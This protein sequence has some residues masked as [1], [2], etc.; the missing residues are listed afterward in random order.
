[1]K[2]TMSK[3]LGS[4]VFILTMFITQLSFAGQQ[5]VVTKLKIGGTAVTDYALSNGVVSTTD[6]VRV[7]GNEGYASLVVIEDKAGGAGDVDIYAEYS[8]DG[9]TWYRPYVSDMAGTITI[10]GNIVT[11]L[12][13]DTRWIVFT[14]R[15]APYIR[16]KLDPDADSEL[17]ATLIHL[18]AY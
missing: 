1:M 7:R 16:F 15:V 6:S 10:E 18:E 9:T 14:P 5:T 2:T 12:G 4:V 13:N 11:T 17:T 3:Y 8:L